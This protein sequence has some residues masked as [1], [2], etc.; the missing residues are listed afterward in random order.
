MHSLGSIRDRFSAK[1]PRLIAQPDWRHAAVAMLIHMDEVKGLQ[2]LMIERA[3][4]EKDPWSGHLALPGGRVEE[5]DANPRNAA[6]RETLEEIGVNL[7]SAEFLGQLDDVDADRYPMI[8]SCY[9]Y[10]LQNQP[11]CS[12]DP[13]EVADIFWLPLSCL[14]EVE[15]QRQIYPVMDDPDRSFPAVKVPGKSQPLW[16][17][18]YKILKRFLTVAEN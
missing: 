10:G 17:I 14:D 6:E 16:G 1:A 11:D 5:Q 18:T 13:V 8:I 2:V 3:K 12:A 9:V 7:N 15:R 4:D